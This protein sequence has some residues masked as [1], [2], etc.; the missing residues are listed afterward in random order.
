MANKN[1]KKEEAKKQNDIITRILN[2]IAET[3]GKKS[4]NE[5]IMKLTAI[6]FKNLSIINKK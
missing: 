5:E 4:T 6:Y 2:K 1:T 3:E